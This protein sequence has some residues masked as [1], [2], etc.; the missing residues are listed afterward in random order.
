MR[1]LL[2]ALALIGCATP[3]RA[4][5]QMSPF[6]PLIGCWRG[7]FDGQTSVHDERCFEPML[8]GRYVRDTH[9]VR[10]TAYGGESIYFFDPGARSLAYAYYA[11]DGAISSGR[12]H[13]EE[14]ALVFEPGEYVGADGARMRL[15]ARW[16][17]DGADRYVAV[18]ERE[19]N[20]VWLPLMRI[21][22]ERVR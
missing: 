10:P 14:G 17:F 15:R 1:A 11:A 3:A 8:G 16:S 9:N 2:L 21:S 4:Q 12:V 6:A 19:E 5:D 7:A 22:Y 20:G 18:T 13:T